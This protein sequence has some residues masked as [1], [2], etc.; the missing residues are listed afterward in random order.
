MQTFPQR[1]AKWWDEHGHS[2]ARFVKAI[3]QR[4]RACRRRQRTK[5]FTK[6][7]RLTTALLLISLLSS[8]ASV[9]VADTLVLPEGR[10]TNEGS[11]GTDLPFYTGSSDL[12]RAA[13]IFNSSQFDSLSGPIAI[14]QIAF[15]VDG[16][17]I[18][19]LSP[20]IDV[21]LPGVQLELSTTR[22]SAAQPQQD[23]EFDVLHGNDRTTVFPRASLHWTTVPQQG[24]INPFDLKIPFAAP[25]VYDPRN[26]NLYIDIKVFRHSN[27]PIILDAHTHSLEPVTFGLYTSINF[28][29]HSLVADALYNGALV[30]EL[31]FQVI[32][33][34]ATSVTL[35]FG[36][37][38]LIAVWK[39]T[40]RDGFGRKKV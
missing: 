28:G 23:N 11:T 20:V 30:T 15:R 32:P 4:H 29:D 35:M 12:D 33:E 19:P 1:C 40:S 3:A 6:M 24:A 25:F 37:A 34:P 9:A 21:T 27:I 31:T 17:R 26:G 13:M 18:Q 22:F 16:N 36:L 39:R 14:S 38:A 2:R 7:K 10:A 5:P 8:V